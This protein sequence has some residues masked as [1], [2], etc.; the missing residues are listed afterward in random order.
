MN[1]FFDQE[2]GGFYFYSKDGETLIH[3]PKEIYDS[4]IPSG[5][6]VALY[7]I[8]KLSRYIGS[9]ELIELK[10]KQMSFM[11]KGVSEY[12]SGHSFAIMA[13]MLETHGTK[14][15]ICL[16]NDE[17]ETME[18]KNLLSNL[19]IP[20]LLVIVKDKKNKEEI[21]KVIPYLKDYPMDGKLPVFYLCENYSCKAPIYDFNKLKKMLIELT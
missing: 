13:G 10:D 4:A 18:L 6:S 11:A 2:E 5:N 1:E 21:E 12:P 14:E 3:R 15:L 7:N 9:K 17:V 8:I 20:N 19:F 16:L